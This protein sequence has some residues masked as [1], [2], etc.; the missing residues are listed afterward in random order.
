[1]GEPLIS[2][3]TARELES[4][5][6]AAFH[7]TGDV[8]RDLHR[9]GREI[10]SFIEKRDIQEEVQEDPATSPVARDRSTE[11]NEPAPTSRQSRI[12]R[13]LQE[14]ERGKRGYRPS[15][16]RAVL[17]SVRRKMKREPQ[18]LR[19]RK[20]SVIRF[21]LS[22]QYMLEN[23]KEYLIRNVQFDSVAVL[24]DYARRKEDESAVL[25]LD[26]LQ[27]HTQIARSLA[28]LLSRGLKTLQQGTNEKEGI[29][30]MDGI[31]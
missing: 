22:L 28:E 16:F 23:R 21:F 2:M 11:P 6:E 27:E 13:R 9:I 12:L 10:Q 15:K 25:G 8:E 31:E 3:G 7:K 14:R 19:Q 17:K 18:E 20:D 5:L 29:E 1:M 30:S 24:A 26:K 4:L